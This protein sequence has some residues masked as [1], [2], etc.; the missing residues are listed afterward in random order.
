MPDN[1]GRRLLSV[2]R[3]AR[4]LN[5]PI[6]AVKVGRS[7]AAAAV[8]RSHTAAL[9]GDDAIYQGAF[10]AAHI[11][12]ADDLDELVGNGVAA[13]GLSGFLR[14]PEASGFLSNS[15]GMNSLFSD[16]CGINGVTLAELGPQ[17]ITG[18]EAILSGFGAAGN[19]ADVTGNI[20]RPA[21]VDLIDLFTADAAVDLMVVGTTGSANGQRSLDIAA[22]VRRARERTKK[23]LVGLWF[24]ALAG[25]TPETSGAAAL[26]E[27]GVPVFAEPSK[28][29]RALAALYAYRRPLAAEPAPVALPAEVSA[30]AWAETQQDALHLLALCGIATAALHATRERG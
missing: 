1:E 9:T 25:A 21:L 12:R 22:N 13:G 24:S 6:L 28:C 2:A 17:T 16:Q 15:G 27:D 8:A 11:T 19:P 23:P 14:R 3:R 4:E 18:I 5:K 20:A 30:G 29:A 7:A 26:A 10:R